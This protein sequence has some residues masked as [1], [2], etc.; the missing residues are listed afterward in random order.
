MRLLSL[1]VAAGYVAF[2]FFIG[3]PRSLND[4]VARTLLLLASV[5]FPLACIWFGDDLTEYLGSDKPAPAGW[6]KAGGWVLLLLP[7]IVSWFVLKA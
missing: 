3:P 2:R 4:A 1:I 7:F 6:V 5:A